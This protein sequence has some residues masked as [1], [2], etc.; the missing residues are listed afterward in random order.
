MISDPPP[1]ADTRPVLRVEGLEKTF[2]VHVQGTEI[3]AL[4]G[5]A[6]AVDPGSITALVGPSG[7]G[8][9]SVL[10]CIYRTYLPS[11][12]RILLRTAEGEIDL[13]A[14]DELDVERIR[15]REMGFVTQFLRCLPRKSAVD[16]VA[17]PLLRQHVAPG[18]ARDR[19][20]DLLDHLALPRNLWHLPPATFSGGEQQRVNIARGF[21]HDYAA[22]LLD[23]PTA[24]LDPAN[25]AVVLD[26][27]REAK[28][29]GAAILGIFHDAQVRAAVCEREVDV[30]AFA[31]DAA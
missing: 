30:G 20:C 19:A 22:L 6:F 26:L 7:A 24:S 13:A 23:E 14:A 8:K 16:V 25:R 28:G 18:E 2:A 12:G 5:L 11:A 17:A 4:R 29:R 15:A 9:S 10:K 21:A 27:I 31:Q 1:A 3:H